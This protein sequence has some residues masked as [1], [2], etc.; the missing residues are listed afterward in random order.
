MSDKRYLLLEVDESRADEL[1][2]ALQQ[3]SYIKHVN[4]FRLPDRDAFDNCPVCKEELANKWVATVTDQMV[5]GCVRILTI[6]K[7]NKTV[8]LYNKSFLDE[9]RPID[10]ERSAPFPYKL[11][12]AARLLGIVDHFVDGTQDTFYVTT[13]G[14]AFLSGDEEIKPAKITVANNV[15]LESSGS[16]WLDDV[17]R[18]DVAKFSEAVIKLRDAIKVIPETTLQF[19]DTG[20]VPLLK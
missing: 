14:M 18:K 12:Y 2:T 10:R 13:K 4:I 17:K 1:L 5:Y 20:Q 19:V 15:V 16:M 11:L 3:R 9:V 7:H 6:M 8:V